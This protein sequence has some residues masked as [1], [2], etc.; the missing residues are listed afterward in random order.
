[1]HEH[2]HVHTKLK[3]DRI[4]NENVIY[5]QFIFQYY[6]LEPKQDYVICSSEL[7]S[8]GRAEWTFHINVWKI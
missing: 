8:M 6:L 4:L 2:K 3:L 5:K 1:M 7:V